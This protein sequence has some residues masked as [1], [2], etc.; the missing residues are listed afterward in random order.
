MPVDSL[1]PDQGSVTVKER[2]K[3]TPVG[4]F[5]RPR[6]DR[7]VPGPVHTGRLK[8]SF[9]ARI[10]MPECPSTEPG[11]HTEQALRI[12]PQT[13]LSAAVQGRLRSHRC[14]RTR[15]QRQHVQ[16]CYACNAHCCRPNS[17]LCGLSCG[18]DQLRPSRQL[19]RGL[20]SLSGAATHC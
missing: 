1:H 10:L 5:G 7:G 20:G 6:I 8:S 18:P 11:V 13:S 3:S 17:D 15:T 9:G 4:V 19:W 12:R 16:I 2:K 14:Q